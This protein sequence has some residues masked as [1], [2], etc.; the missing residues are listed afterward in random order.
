[1]LRLGSYY[2]IVFCFLSVFNCL[3]KN[4]ISKKDGFV[5]KK[6][7][8]NGMTI[9]TR[10]VHNIPKV[11]IQIFYHVGSKDEKTGEKGIAHLIEHMVFKGTEKLSESD[12]N[13]ISHMLSGSCNAFTSYDYTGYM[14]NMPSQNWK[15]MLP[16]MA[17]C[18]SNCS[19]KDE[20]LNSEMKAVIQ[21]LKM[22]KDN[23]LRSIFF[24]M[25]TLIF[26][27]HP[28]HYPLIG[29]K[30][31]LCDVRGADL[32]SFYRKHYL[33]N[34]ATLVVV[35]DV[36]SEE[37]F[38]LAEKQFGKIP[39]DKDYKKESFYFNR[40]IVSKTITLHRSVKQP[41]VIF[42]FVVPGLTSANDHLLDAA[43]LFLGKGKSSRLYRRLVDQMQLATS[44]DADSLRLFDHSLFFI[45]F[46]PK[47]INDVDTIKSVI[48]QE[49]D[50]IIS[51]GL[52]KNEI[53]RAIKQ[54]KMGYYS[55]LENIQSQAYDI[56]KSFL[57]T[58]DENYAFTYLDKLDKNLEAGIQ[59]LFA[60][61]LRPVVM[62]QG[63]V[64]PL[65]E[66][67]KQEWNKLQKISDQQDTEI[68]SARVRESGIEP[69]RYA[70]NVVISEPKQFDFPKPKTF[71]LSNGIK[72]FYCDNKNTPKIDLIVELRAKSFYDPEEMQG[73]Y[74]FVA[75]MMT[76]G[77]K[78]YTAEQLAD[79]IELRGMS[80]DVSP[81]V[82]S[83]SMLS[84]DLPKGLE[85]LEEVLNR[86]RFDKKEMEKVRQQIL[87]DIKNFWDDPN[88]ISN[89]LLKGKIYEGHPYSKHA[90]GSKETVE[91]IKRKDLVAFHK[92][93]ISPSGA[94]ISIV[95]DLSA[96]NL[97]KVLEDTFAKW[98]GPDVDK[99]EFPPLE[100]TK[101]DAVQYHIDRDQM[102]VALAALSIDR[103]DKNYDNFILF[104]QIFGGGV[105]GAMNSK[106]FQLREQ[107]GLFYTIFGSLT[108]NSGEQPGVFLVKTIVSLDRLNEAKEAIK[109]TIDTAAETVTEV[110]LQEAKR[111]ITN[112]LMN[113]FDSNKKIAATFLFL[114]K[115][116]FADSYFDRRAEQIAKI[117][118]ADVTSAVKTI[119]D[120]EHMVTLLVGR[121][122]DSTA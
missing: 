61:Y 6:T 40:D 58:G 117:K 71:E 16:I 103:K 50:S 42:A 100:P 93:Y 92:N 84:S 90:L 20:H 28:Y 69:P 91:K 8:S 51:E 118:L 54:S 30:Q 80:L 101:K 97:Q 12:I 120:S 7:L 23:Y 68:L 17:D 22:L 4:M 85:I 114:D 105:L 110:E 32:R 49:I 89:Y 76:E 18:M 81:G 31:D 78:K 29:Y 39:A 96:Y 2:F 83:M 73:L 88:S 115:Y 3:G 99:I 11:T 27:D 108:A 112:T 95:G 77:T 52:T 121:V 55:K 53:E 13:A 72:V 1:M 64:L 111:A 47:D 94:K 107:T 109:K 44:L 63:V 113:N 21:E 34:N 38:N 45:C 87:T 86:P 43:E 79:E 60:Q 26:P 70:K 14:F 57:A 119:L 25:L 82:I 62:H 37:V 19:F 35:G 15:E 33:P 106:L 66:K 59:K 10:E 74:N 122:H 5:S 98:E 67:E 102:V 46:E 104:D 48:C 41:V 65:D 56:G 36:D 116:N 75:N 9:L 24:E